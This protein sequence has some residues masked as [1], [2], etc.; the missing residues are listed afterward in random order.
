[1]SKK[2]LPHYAAGIIVKGFGRG[3]KELGIPTANY[4]LEVVKQLPNDIETG[5]YFGWANIDNGDIHKMVM[6]IGWNPFFENQEKSMETHI[7][8]PYNRD[9]YGQVLKVCIC[10]YIRPEKN[11][12]SLEAL[13]ST[14]NDDIEYANLALERGEF[15]DMKKSNFFRES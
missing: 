2:S 12:D 5:I 4:P 7:M 8:Y 14:I 15:V 13:I 9:L 6:S 11:F 10:G 1:M 3:S